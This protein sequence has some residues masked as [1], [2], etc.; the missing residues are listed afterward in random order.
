V[1]VPID[2]I[3]RRAGV[4]AGTVYRHFPMKESLF[5]AI[6]ANR[7][8]RLVNYA[9]SST[10]TRD[11]GIS[12]FAFLTTMVADGARITAQ[13]AGAVRLGIDVHE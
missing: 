2:E 5:E 3:A 4:G 11:P 6:V 1:G 9:R 8:E 7:I 12:L 13:R 10:G